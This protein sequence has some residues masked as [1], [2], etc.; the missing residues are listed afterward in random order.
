MKRNEVLKE[1]TWATEDLFPSDAEWEKALLSVDM[2][3]DELALYAGKI[4]KDANALFLYLKRSEEINK[5]L[6]K[7]YCYAMLKADEDLGNSKYVGYKGKIMSALTSFSTKTSFETPEIVSISEDVLNNFY[8][9]CPDLKYFKRAIDKRRAFK[10]YTLSEIEENILAKT[11]DISSAVRS[12]YSIF[13]NADMKFPDIVGADGQFLS[14][15]SGSFIK[16]LESKDRIIREQAFKSVYSTYSGFKNTIAAMFDAQIKQQ[17]FYSKV[18]G[19]GSNIDRALFNN[20]VPVDVYNNLIKAVNNHLPSLHKY[21]SLRKKILALD[22]LHFYDIYVPMVSDVD[23]HFSFDEAKDLVI[24]ALS[25]LGDEYCKIIQ[26]GFD[27]RWIDVYENEGKRSGAYSCGTP[28][29]PYVLLNFTGTLDSVFTLIHEMGHAI[30]SYLSNMHQSGIYS[31]YVIFVAEVASTFNESLLTDY[32][33]KNT[34]D[35]K[36]KAYII[37]HF[38]EQ[39]KGTLFRQTMFAEFEL[40]INEKCEAGETLTADLLTDYYFQLNKKYYGDDIICDE[41]ISYEW[42]RIPHFFMNYYVYQYATGFSAALALSE[43]VLNEGINAVN[44]YL[45][46]LSSGCL[47]DPVSL[48]R[49]AGVN[50]ES[51]DPIDK[52]LDRFDSLL[53]EMEEIIF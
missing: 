9:D 33:L 35:K 15:T 27:N 49:Q 28:V 22:E 10:P 1:N 44:S 12:V 53:N 26:M 50:M 51:S 43:K 46:F 3:A 41:E 19:F 16:N 8:L 21:I 52:A 20:E 2:Y 37:N 24:K 30:H 39:F 36:Q 42:E 38:L 45:Q 13:T 48:L 17:R 5:E 40:F 14:V 23:I 47:K 18:R 32:L 25:P 11:G 34:V 6:E 31:D 7:I 29:H 4:S